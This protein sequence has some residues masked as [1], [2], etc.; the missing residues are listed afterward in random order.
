MVPSGKFSQ[1]IPHSRAI[2]KRIRIFIRFPRNFEL[3]RVVSINTSGHKFGLVYVGLGWIIWRDEKYLP[4]SLVFSLDYL[5]GT[6]KSFTLN[7]SRPGAQVVLQYYNLIH[8]GFAGY[9]EVMENCLRN[10]R[11]LSRALEETGWYTVVSDIHRPVENSREKVAASLENREAYALKT[12]ARRTSLSGMFDDIT[13]A[14]YVAG[15]PVVAFRFSDRFQKQF[16]YVKQESVSLMMR[17]RQWI[18]PNYC[19]PSNESN[20]QILRIVVRE[21]MSLDL[22]EKLVED[23][24]MVTEALME[25]EKVDLSTLLTRH[26]KHRSRSRSRHGRTH[27]GVC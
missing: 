21:N 2:C 27:R 3:P 19:L 11:L 12:Q 18:I 4:D 20:V 8:L 6:E 5:G 14:D 24:C 10:A 17:A 23:I 25:S 7:F 16:P 15:L 9:R 13:S 26:K 22:L 1:S